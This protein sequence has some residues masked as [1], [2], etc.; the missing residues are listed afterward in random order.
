MPRRSEREN[1][2][3]RLNDLGTSL[4]KHG[5]QQIISRKERGWK[6][7]TIIDSLVG[8]SHWSQQIVEESQVPGPSSSHTRLDSF[9]TSNLSEV[10]MAKLCQEGGSR[11]CQLFACKSN[12][13]RPMMTMFF[14]DPLENIRE[15]SFRDIQRLSAAEQKEWR[16]A[17]QDELQA[18]RQRQVYDLVDRPKDKNVIKCRWVF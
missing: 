14:L 2:G 7:D 4:V 16:K 6:Y 15:W 10:E 9:D 1:K 18:L 13:I 5:S 11:T 8:R 3:F 17:C 12:S